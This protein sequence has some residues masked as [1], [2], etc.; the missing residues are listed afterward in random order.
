MA[1]TELRSAPPVRTRPA[2]GWSL[3]LRHWQLYL[4]MLPA[5][6]YFLIF[7]YVPMY[8]TL[9]AF[10][11]FNA[12]VGI[13]GSPWA[14]FEHFE[15]FFSSYYFWRLLR[16]TL[17]LNLYLLVLFPLPILLALSVNELAN[18]SFKKWVQTLTYAPHFI[19]VV[20]VVGMM[21]TFLDPISGL[22]NH[23]VLEF[24]GQPIEFLTAPG[25]FR[26]LFVW[27]NIWQS[28]GWASIIYLAALA[29]VNMELHDV[30][31]VDGATRLQRIRH[32]NIPAIL[33]TVIVLLILEM[34]K[35]M[36]IGFE[37]V[38]LMQNELNS[39]TS[40]VIQTFV[41]DS[42]LL[43]GQYSY[44]AAIGLFDS[45]INIV[46]VVTMNQLARKTSEHSLW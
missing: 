21:V 32:I 1:I 4:F 36:T 39:T 17:L 10:K 2:N 16:N 9:I 8:G 46:L 27:S 29:G 20:V 28:V 7:H 42:G 37:K 6:A 41:Y 25:W 34:G 15:R 3:A 35:F 40:D 14:G 12:A 22:V 13:W 5:L 30:A 24:G 38:L 44:A 26:H 33:P 19:S 45:V 43:Q 23:L 31:K 11:N 18:G